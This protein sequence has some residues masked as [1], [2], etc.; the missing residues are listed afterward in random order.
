M[1]IEIVVV[2][3]SI[4]PSVVVGA[5][6]ANVITDWNPAVAVMQAIVGAVIGLAVVEFIGL[7][8]LVI[9]ATTIA[10]QTINAIGTCIALWNRRQRRKALNGDYGEVTMWATEIVDDGDMDFAMAIQALSEA[11]KMEIGIIAD[12]KEEL[13]NL[14]IDRLDE[15]AEEEIPEDFA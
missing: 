5:T 12:D 7:S 1:V 2:L 9:V 11:D 10:S 4:I 15:V 13:R 8:S 3:A 6:I 14:V